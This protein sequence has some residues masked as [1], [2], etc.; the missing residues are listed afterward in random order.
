M[1]PEPQTPPALANLMVAGGVVLLV[2]GSVWLGLELARGG[3]LWD[4]WWANWLTP[5]AGLLLLSYGVRRLQGG[6]RS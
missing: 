2:V 5:A 4:V 3:G 1:T 6:R